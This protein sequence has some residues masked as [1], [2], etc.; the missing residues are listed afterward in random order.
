MEGT[1]GQTY[2]AAPER[3]ESSEENRRQM[4]TEKTEKPRKVRKK[5]K[6]NA[7]SKNG[8]VTLFF[9]TGRILGV[10]RESVLRLFRIVVKE[11]NP[12]RRD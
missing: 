7:K 12:I 10:R 1:G 4:T 3:I 8:V 2:E 6:K 5:R 9:P 11:Y